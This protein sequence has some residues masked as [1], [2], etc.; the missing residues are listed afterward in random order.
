MIVSI[1]NTISDHILF[2][3]LTHVP[4]FVSNSVSVKNTLVIVAFPFKPFA[5]CAISQA[6]EVKFQ[7]TRVVYGDALSKFSIQF[8]VRKEYFF[9]LF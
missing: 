7:F 8:Y 1:M 5:S 3:M 6:I 2:S 9:F 4:R